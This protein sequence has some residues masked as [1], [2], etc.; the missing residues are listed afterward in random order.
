MSDNEFLQ[1]LIREFYYT[2][3]IL[4]FLQQ[5]R[6]HFISKPA[7]FCERLEISLL[8]IPEQTKFKTK[9]KKTFY[10]STSLMIFEVA[11]Q[12]AE[13]GVF[14]SGYEELCLLRCNAM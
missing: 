10:F 9:I 7:R 14:V 13:F 2:L 3:F 6:K 1:T 5:N 11:N 4:F 8:N 12:K